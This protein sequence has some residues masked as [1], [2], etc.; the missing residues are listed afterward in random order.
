M[1]D[2]FVLTAALLKAFYALVAVV[3]AIYLSA[4]LDNRANKPWAATIEIIVT[5]PVAA[6]VYYGLRILGICLLLGLLMGCSSAKA[7]PAF[8]DRYDRQI[9]HAAEA[10]WPDYP[11]WLAWKAQLYQESRL[12]P[13][14]VS[15]V[16]AAG[17]AQIMPATW[18]D[19]TRELRL[20]GASPHHDIAIEAGAYYMARL[21]RGWMTERPPDDRQRLAQ[22]SYNA[23]T[24]NLLKA[25]RLCDG[26]LYAEIVPC[27]VAVTGERNA[28]ETRTY[29]ERIAK[30]RGMMAAGL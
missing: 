4:W 2:D 7:G 23:G 27:L 26:I 12:D 19:L 30:W 13:A 3:G 11:H 18:A 28:R 17:L 24:G 14:A 22:A 15:P 10:Y 25:Q 21:R 29:V 16:G 9:R 6:A 20:G 5:S 8:P 1:L